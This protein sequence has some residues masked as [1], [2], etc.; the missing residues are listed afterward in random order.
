MLKREFPQSESDLLPAERAAVRRARWRWLQGTA[1]VIGLSALSVL[2]IGC[3]EA[4]DLQNPCN[5]ATPEAPT[6]AGGPETKPPPCGTKVMMEAKDPCEVSCVDQIFKN[7]ALCGI[8]HDGNPGKAMFSKLD[9]VGANYT[10]R[11][12][13]VAAVHGDLP[14][15]KTTCGTGDKLIDT[16]NPSASW[17]L[18]KIDGMQG[19]CGDA[20]PTTGPLSTDQKACLT[21][22]V[23]CVAGGAVPTGGMGGMPASGG[24]GAAAGGAAGMGGA[25]AGMGGTGGNGGMGGQ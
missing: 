21:T 14:A 23:S 2:A 25:A 10:K 19:T 13:D 12:K 11:L 8:C 1:A 7:P 24:A 5:Y 4:A 15:G 18:K 20:M 6:P 9:L 22:Y 17:L 3:P 16:A